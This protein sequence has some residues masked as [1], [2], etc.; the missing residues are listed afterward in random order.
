MSTLRF[1]IVFYTIHNHL[2][3]ARVSDLHDCNIFFIK[4]SAYYVLF[5]L[6]VN[7]V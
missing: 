3:G 4:V 5:G 6:M 2:N 7:I 1:T